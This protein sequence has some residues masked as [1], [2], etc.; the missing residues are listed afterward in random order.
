MK[1]AFAIASMGGTPMSHQ[2]DSR[3][4]HLQQ[5]PAH[6]VIADTAASLHPARARSQRFS[7]MNTRIAS[8]FY[9]SFITALL[10][11]STVI[12][13]EWPDYRGPTHD[14]V[15]TEKLA[16]WTSAP[17]ELWRLKIGNGLGTFAVAGGKAY[18]YALEG[19][20]ES[21]IAI[22]AISGK[23]LWARQ[24]DKTTTDRSG[25]PA[26]R[27]TPA[28]DGDRVYVISTFL[29]LAC[30]DTKSGK[31]LWGHDLY[32]EFQ[33]P[34]KVKGISNWG[35]A[36]SP[37]IDGN[38]VYIA[39]GGPGKSLMAFDKKTGK[40][41]WGMGDE[42]LTH[43]SPAIATIQ[44]VRQI[45]FFV[46]SGLVSCET[47]TGKE[48]WR[49]DV[50]FDTSTAASPIVYQ[51]IV[52]CSAGYG[53]N[54][55]GACRIGKSGDKLSAAKIWYTP[56]RNI[57]HWSTPVCKDGNLYGLF[58]FKQF[59]TEPLKCVEIATGKELWSQDGFGQGGVQLVGDHLVVQGDEG[60][61][62]LVDAS[63]TGYHEAGRTEPL[64]GKC[65][66][67]PVVSDGR[68]YARSITEAVC[69]DVSG[70]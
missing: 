47:T 15:S 29:K 18:L 31:I 4:K 20:Q 54:G 3:I 41:V 12:A 23:P 49:W 13:A 25:E 32:T 59:K 14:G 46:Q 37:T 48:L 6:A 52:Y 63:P 19:G 45:I 11:A 50:P 33:A 42:K 2:P 21:C 39:G 38:L 17:K 1:F 5:T 66:N 44:G 43:A 16:P 60:Q 51:D 61:I 36:Q 22:D 62:V 64:H 9:G 57:N 27:S 53:K 55:G 35:S 26:P 28:V 67:M 10:A 69:L 8:F 30:L 58:G 24:I 40:P 70:K 65:W 68:L 34:A 7:S 56:G